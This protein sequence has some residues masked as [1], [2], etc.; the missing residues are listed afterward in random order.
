MVKQS[1]HFITNGYIICDAVQEMIEEDEKTRLLGKGI[2]IVAEEETPITIKNNNGT[3]GE[4]IDTIIDTINT[5]FKAMLSSGT[6]GVGPVTFP[7]LDTAIQK[8]TDM[9]K[10]LK[11]ILA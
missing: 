11:E 5:E 7:Q 10:S 9:I 8:L 6:C 1:K 3:V 2:D 4:K